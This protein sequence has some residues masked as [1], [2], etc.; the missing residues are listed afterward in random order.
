MLKFTHVVDND[1]TVHDVHTYTV[2]F[3][4][5]VLIK[6]SIICPSKFAE[7]EFCPGGPNVA[8]RCSSLSGGGPNVACQCSVVPGSGRW[9]GVAVCVVSWSVRVIGPLA[10]CRA[11]SGALVCRRHRH[12]AASVCVWRWQEHFLHGGSS[13]IC[14]AMCRRGSGGYF[15]R[16]MVDTCFVLEFVRGHCLVF[17][18]LL[19]VCFTATFCKI[20]KT[21]LLGGRTHHMCSDVCVWVTIWHVQTTPHRTHA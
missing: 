12:G 15:H 6:C 10:F 14:R 8:G 11:R 7:S 17:T 3:S 5:S 2:A 13:G 18:N 16:R 9:V 19:L 21:L 1:T 4:P 20:R